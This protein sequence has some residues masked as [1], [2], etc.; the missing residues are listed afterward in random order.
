MAQQYEE[1]R[2]SNGNPEELL[3]QATGGYSPEQ[4]NKF[5]N[6]VKGFGITDEQLD[7]YGINAK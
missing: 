7:K 6:F 4:M 5:R 3:R 1:L 2:K